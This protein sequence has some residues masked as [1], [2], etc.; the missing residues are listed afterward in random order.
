MMTDP[1]ADMLTRIRN[2]LLARHDRV[3]IPASNTKR[4]IARI[5]RDEGYV[6][7]YQQLEEGPQ[8]EIEVELKYLDGDGSAITGIQRVSSPGRRVYCGRNTLPRIYNGLG[9]AIISTSRGILTDRQ[10][11][12]HG[13]GGEVLCKVW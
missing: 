4:E 9:V 7:A 12:E 8:G 6:K 5:L 11:R 10:C 13:I 1:V 3:R 2:G